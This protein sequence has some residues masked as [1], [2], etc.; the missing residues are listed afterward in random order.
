M[1]GDW[2]Q[3]CV[4]FL[5]RPNLKPSWQ[6]QHAAAHDFRRSRIRQFLMHRNR[7]KNLLNQFSE[8]MLLLNGNQIM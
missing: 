5:H 3:I 1:Q 7:D 4:S 2:K 8:Q 6:R